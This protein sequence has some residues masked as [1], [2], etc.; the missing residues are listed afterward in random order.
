MN[1]SFNAASNYQAVSSE[2][3]SGSIWGQAWQLRRDIDQAQ[4]QGYDVSDAQYFANRGRQALD[5]GNQ[6][7]AVRDFD[8][9]QAALRESGF[10]GVQEASG[11]NQ[12]S[13]NQARQLRRDI[14]RARAQGFDVTDAQ[15]FADQGRIALEAGNT[16]KA[17]REFAAAENLLPVSAQ[18]ESS[19]RSQQAYNKRY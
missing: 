14:N 8:K 12:A 4:A 3:R 1:R 15:H 17:A 9:A 10:E 16:V 13:W 6:N 7:R 18:E 2:S 19:G 11:N 5:H